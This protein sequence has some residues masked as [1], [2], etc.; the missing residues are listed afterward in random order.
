MSSSYFRRGRT[1]VV[2]YL[3]RGLL[4]LEGDVDLD[5]GSYEQ[6]GVERKV[7]FFNIK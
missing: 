4:S 3:P 1:V 5:H 2:P 7:V 6:P